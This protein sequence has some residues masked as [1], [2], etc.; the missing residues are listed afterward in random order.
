[1][2]PLMVVVKRTDGMARAADASLSL[3][4]IFFG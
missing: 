1:M 4:G 3:Q 2:F